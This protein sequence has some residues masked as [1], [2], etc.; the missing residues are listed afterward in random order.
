[1]RVLVEAM[2]LPAV[3]AILRVQNKHQHASRGR[4]SS[5][6]VVIVGFDKAP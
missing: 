5:Y 4:I 6:T 3:L 1:M 2:R